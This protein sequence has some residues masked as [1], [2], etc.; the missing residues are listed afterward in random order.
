L[1]YKIAPKFD[2]SKVEA[3]MKDGLL[4]LFI[5]TAESQKTKVVKIK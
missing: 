4:H 3:N 5:P 1:G 2:L